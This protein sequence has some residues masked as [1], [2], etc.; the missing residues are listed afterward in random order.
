M[1]GADR[2]RMV[3][4]CSMCFGSLSAHFP[5]PLIHTMGRLI[6][7]KQYQTYNIFRE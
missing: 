2:H 5:K 6:D 7:N 4:P 1:C 3:D